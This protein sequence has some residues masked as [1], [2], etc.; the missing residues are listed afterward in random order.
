MLYVMSDEFSL[1]EASGPSNTW[2]DVLFLCFWILKT[3]DK[4]LAPV[5]VKARYGF[6]VLIGDSPGS[7]SKVG[8]FLALLLLFSVMR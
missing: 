4:K 5:L 3:G 8:Y 7:I 1:N 2:V 6:L